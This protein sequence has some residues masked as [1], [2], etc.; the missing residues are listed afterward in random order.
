MTGF[1]TL[2]LLARGG[3]LALLLLWSWLLLRD[4]AGALAARMA[5]AMNLGIAAHVVATLPGPVV[6]PAL[7]TLFE[8]GSALVPPFFWLFARTWFNDEK[9]IGW[10]SWTLVGLTVA[11]VLVLLWAERDRGPLFYGAVAAMRVTMFAYAAAGL[12]VA[13]RGRDDD[14]V[15]QRRRLRMALV[16]AVGATVIAVNIIE[17]LVYNDV[18]APQWRSAIEFIIAAMAFGFCAAVF[19]IA[20][21]DLFA[22][23]AGVR[24]MITGGTTPDTDDPLIAKLTAYMQAELPHREEG[25]TIAQLAVR[26]GEQEYRLRRAINGALGYRNFAQFLNSYRLAEVK[27]A[28]ADPAQRDVPILT[29]AL[30]AGFGSLGPFNRAFRDAEG[31]TPTAFRARAV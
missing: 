21:T 10:R 28:L 18:L 24:T 15:E 11:L 9:R 16:A 27:A 3:S 29:I 14:L 8:I 30:D 26:L 23:A 20:Q 25:L 4:Q 19:S 31:M 13:W 1:Q 7:D 17:I 6:N 12:W 22:P 5:I 2:D